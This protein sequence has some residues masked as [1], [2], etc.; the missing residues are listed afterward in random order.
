MTDEKRTG[1]IPH[2]CI[3]EDRRT[4]SVSGVNDVGSF[5]EEM[6]IASTDYGELTVKGEKLHITKLSLEIGEL[7]IEGNIAAI[8]YADVPDKNVSFFSKVFR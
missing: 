5:D 7:C 8:S 3:L 2:N 1:L 4:L 6:I